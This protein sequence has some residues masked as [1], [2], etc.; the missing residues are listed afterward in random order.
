MNGRRWCRIALA[1]VAVVSG[2]AMVASN[3]LWAAGRGGGGGG[4]GMRGGGMQGSGMH[5]GG[6]HG[7]SGFHH[8]GFH[9][10][11]V[12]FFAVGAGWPGWWGYAYDG[13]PYYP[14]YSAYS[15]YP[16]TPVTYIEKGDGSDSAS[17]NDWWY[18]CNEPN[19][20]YPYV[21]DCPAGW[22]VELARPPS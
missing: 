11:H 21:Q 8:G 20:Y 16:T 2:A 18:R 6:F 13:W 7:H 22:Q 1:V 12:A 4:G 15:A 14:A 19:G 9:H 17:A 3:P 5:G 10:G